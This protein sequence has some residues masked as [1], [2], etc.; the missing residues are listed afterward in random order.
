MTYKYKSNI[1]YVTNCKK[2]VCN[3]FNL[4]RRTHF[5]YVILQSQFVTLN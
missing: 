4:Q 1:M 2:Y 5:F 3:Y